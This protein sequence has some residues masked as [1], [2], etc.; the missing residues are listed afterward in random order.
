ME[1]LYKTTFK[2]RDYECDLQGIV[3]NSVYLNYFEHTRH[4]FLKHIGF[5]FAHLHSLQ[6]DPVVYR[7]EIDYKL[8]LKSGD[9]FIS[10]INITQKGNLKLMFDQQIFRKSDNKLMVKGL[11]TAVILKNGKPIKP[12]M[13]TEKFK[14]TGT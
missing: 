4:E 14:N 2:V 13:F 5:D 9:E 7:A 11:I 3:N 6:I 10:T 8:P 1:T 12:T